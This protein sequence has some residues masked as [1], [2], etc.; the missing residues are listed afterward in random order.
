MLLLYVKVKILSTSNGCDAVLA[1]VKYS[2]DSHQI[3]A[4]LE[5]KKDDSAWGTIFW[6]NRSGIAIS[7]KSVYTENGLLAG[8]MH[9]RRRERHVC[10]ACPNAA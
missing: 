10:S 7:A 6:H 5:Q 9:Q 3:Y 2:A 1:E 4:W 8:F